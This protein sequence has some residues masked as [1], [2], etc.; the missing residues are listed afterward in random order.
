M[1]HFMISDVSVFSGCFVWTRNHSYP[2]SE[3][4][5]IKLFLQIFLPPS[6]Q[7]ETF[8]QFWPTGCL[9]SIGHQFLT[10]KAIKFMSA[11]DIPVCSLFTGKAL[12]KD[13]L[14]SEFSQN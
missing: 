13:R 8:T 3:G 12:A 7:V 1:N 9:I 4:D 14:Q 6:P 10:N 5:N 11:H 2:F